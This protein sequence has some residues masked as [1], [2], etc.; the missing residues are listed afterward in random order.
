MVMWKNI[1]VVRNGAVMLT[2]VCLLAGCGSDSD[3]ALEYRDIGIEQYEAGDY[4]AAIDY[5]GQ[6]LEEQSSR[7][8][9]RDLQLFLASS[10]LHL[11]EYETVLEVCEEIEEYEEDSD[12]LYLKGT[13]LLQLERKT[14]SYECFAEAVAAD[15]KNYDLY[16][17]IYLQ[18]KEQGDEAEGA[19]YL[20]QVLNGAT[21]R[22]ESEYLQRGRAYYY[23]N[24]TE[25]AIAELTSAQEK[26]S[27]E[28]AVYLGMIE[29]DAGNYETALAIYEEWCSE[30]N[31]SADL[32]N[33]IAACKLQLGDVSAL[34][35]I[36]AGLAL[37][38][39]SVRQELLY[40]E[41]V[42]YELMGEYQTAC[43]KAESYLQ[44]YPDDEDMQQE[45]TFLKTR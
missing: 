30:N 16:L 34:A 40:H 24:E 15:S 17:D 20:Q 13:A 4:K 39:R 1:R 33:R 27:S 11:H 38:E 7:G 2:I 21:G 26:G 22:K 45:Y 8:L 23:L 25:N 12:V 14:E 19:A 6:A 18:M 43:E 36:E 32:Y 29:E 41:V 31:A 3:E 28:A 10:W 35:D 5:F 44:L 9:T 37:E 42:V